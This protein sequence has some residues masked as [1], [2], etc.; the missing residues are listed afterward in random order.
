MTSS[1]FY[2]RKKTKAKHSDG[3]LF[4]LA[5]FDPHLGII[6]HS[7][8]F[9]LPYYLL[10]FFYFSSILIRSIGLGKVGEAYEILN[11][12]SLRCDIQTEQCSINRQTRYCDCYTFLLRWTD[13]K[14]FCPIINPPN[15]SPTSLVKYILFCLYE[16]FYKKTSPKFWPN[17]RIKLRLSIFP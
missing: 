3:P 12:F 10:I 1:G 8:A 9:S 11:G 5:S 7:V 17:F 13:A 2:A 14:C 15:T 16:Q 6:S 4:Q